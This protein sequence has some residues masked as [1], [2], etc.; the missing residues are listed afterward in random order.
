MLFEKEGTPVFMY[1]VEKPRDD[2]ARKAAGNELRAYGEYSRITRL[3]FENKINLPLM[4]NL[5]YQG[6]RLLAMTLL[7][8]SNDSL[9]YG[10]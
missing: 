4:A 9:I 7:P 5:D 6:H 2:L 3:L 8:L 10:N 1:G